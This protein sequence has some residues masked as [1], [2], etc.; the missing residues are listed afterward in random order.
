[1]KSSQLTWKEIRKILPHRYPF[2]LVDKVLKVDVEKGTIVAQK[3]VTLNEEIFLGH[4]P[5]APVM[6]GVLII[7]A[8][9]QTGGILVYEKTKT[10]KIALLLNIVGAKFRRPVVPGDILI[11]EVKALHMSNN[12]GKI[13]AKAL[14]DNK[15]VVEAELS[16]AL[17]DRSKL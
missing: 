17:I 1:M 15:T 7:E 6:P 5:E 2:L 12:G 9:A 3:N 14:V 11:L 10:P 4:F 8:L 13:A 16:F